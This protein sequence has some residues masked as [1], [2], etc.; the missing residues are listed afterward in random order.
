MKGGGGSSSTQ[1]AVTSNTIPP[2]IE[3]R[4][5][6]GLALGEDAIG[7]YDSRGNLVLDNYR[8][9]YRYNA[10]RIADF[11][12]DEMNTFANTRNAVGEQNRFL[13]EA[14]SF[15]RMGARSYDQDIKDQY[16]NSYAKNVTDEMARLSSK[17]LLENVL[18]GVNDT[19]IKGGTFGGT[20]N[21]DF[22][23]RAIDEE[24]RR[25]TGQQADYLS[26]NEKDANANMAD[27]LGRYRQGGVDLASLGKQTQEQR[28]IDLLR[29]G[30]IGQQIRNMD[31]RRM[32]DDEARFIEQRD[33]Q[34]NMANYLLGIASN[35]GD[36]SGTKTETASVP[37][38][39]P[40]SQLAGIVGGAS[41]FAAGGKVKRKKKKVMK[42][43]VKK[44]APKKKFKRKG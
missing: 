35:T 19:F 43:M 41:Q 30:T 10:P 24:A 13:D 11:S 33:Y 39:N 15:A 20:R 9:T 25:L 6:T 36:K 28:G 21:T 23:A 14:G 38:A 16:A 18:P 26:A 2:Y 8:D 17:N 3:S 44:S 40:Y 27:A 4:L 31:Q 7:S 34:K 37:N 29:T 12:A 1:Q 32:D 22:T 42:K 5:K